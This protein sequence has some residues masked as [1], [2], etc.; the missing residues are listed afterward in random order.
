MNDATYTVGADRKYNV[1]RDTIIRVLVGSQSLG[2]N[3][4][5]TDDRD[6]MGLMVEPPDAVFGLDTC[7]HHVTRT[8]PEGVRSGPGDLDLAIYSLKKW[9]RLACKGNPTVLNILYAPEPLITLTPSGKLLRQYAAEIVSW[10]AIPAFIGY[11]TAQKERLLGTRGQK[12]VQRPELEEA[13]GY[14]TKFAM[15]ALRLGLQG[16]ELM[17][18]GR[19]TL[20]LDEERRATCMAVRRGEVDKA[21]AVRLMEDAEARLKRGVPFPGKSPLREK[22]HYI[23]IHKLME[24]IYREHWSAN[25]LYCDANRDY[26]SIKTLARD[27]AGG[28][29]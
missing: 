7:D 6:E 10:Q 4:P 3:N 5:G 16:I 26:Q 2:L 9:M 17:E 21:E 19:L 11:L 24:A 1:E 14:D 28:N 13:H 25:R 27:A 8:Q 23:L 29:T 20:P 15:H 22:P 18:T 12:R